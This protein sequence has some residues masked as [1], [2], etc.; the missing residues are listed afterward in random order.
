MLHGVKVYFVV[1]QNVHKRK[2]VNYLVVGV[3]GGIR[4]TKM[5]NRLTADRIIV[6]SNKKME[7]VVTWY[8]NS[9]ESLKKQKF[10]TPFNSGVIVFVEEDLELG[11][12]VKGDI[13]E[14]VI[15]PKSIEDLEQR[16][17]KKVLSALADKFICKFDYR[18]DINHVGNVRFTDDLDKGPLLAL[19]LVTTKDDTVNKCCF[20]FK[21][22]M[23]YTVN[24]KKTVVKNNKIIKLSFKNHKSSK[25]KKPQ[26]L[27]QTTYTLAD[28]PV[29][30]SDSS[31]ELKRPY[32]KPN[33]EV[34]VRGHY[35]H[36]K[37]GKVVWIKPSIKYKGNESIRKEY[38]L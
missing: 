38:E 13:I 5:I 23:F 3:T 1:T 21:A 22:L 28:I 25:R 16:C 17:N 29:V 4:S 30:E 7:E 24:F 27:I 8:Q 34:K 35:R 9:R 36:Y 15:Y 14:M 11:F 2:K 10:P 19:M 6:P 32:T 31:T 33:T 20:K 26:K 12:E 18:S 37:S